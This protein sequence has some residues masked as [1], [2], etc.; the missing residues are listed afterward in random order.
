MNLPHHSDR[1]NHHDHSHDRHDHYVHYGHHD[2]CGTHRLIESSNHEHYTTVEHSHNN[3]SV[4]ITQA[5]NSYDKRSQIE[6][7]HHGHNRF[8]HPHHYR[9]HCDHA[10]YEHHHLNGDCWHCRLHDFP[11]QKE[12]K[13]KTVITI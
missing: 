11:T 5:G 3:G 10:H 9:I 8:V 2:H 12:A 7:T 13:V 6:Y 4:K 1:F